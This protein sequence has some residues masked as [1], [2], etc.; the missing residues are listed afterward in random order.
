MN[1]LESAGT[2]RLALAAGCVALGSAVSVATF[3]VVGEPFGTLNDVGNA[4]LGLL[5]AALAWRLRGRLPRRFAALTVGCAM[6]GAAIV[7][8]GSALVITGATGWFLAALVSTLGYAGIGTWL[9]ALN[10]SPYTEAWPRR[11]RMVGVTAGALLWLGI[12]AAPGV[13]M[14]LDDSATAPGWAWFAM[15]AWLGIYVALPAWALWLARGAAVAPDASH[16][17]SPS[18]TS[19]TVAGS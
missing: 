1:A 13:L 12:V 7:V 17:R 2:R 8:T 14:G 19:S 6:A 16:L 11:M 4:A 15:T 3:S 10:R 18:A 9:V 5:S